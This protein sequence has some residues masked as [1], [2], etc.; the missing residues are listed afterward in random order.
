MKARRQDVRHIWYSNGGSGGAGGQTST[1]SSSAAAIKASS[2]N[3]D[4]DEVN[5]DE[6]FHGLYKNSHHSPD[7]NDRYP[8]LD[9]TA[10]VSDPSVGGDRSTLMSSTNSYHFSPSNSCLPHPPSSFYPPPPPPGSIE[11]LMSA[12][13]AAAGTAAGRLPLTPN[14]AASIAQHFQA[15]YAGLR[16][17][18]GQDLGPISLIGDGDGVEDEEEGEVE[19]VMSSCGVS[20]Y[21]ENQDSRDSL[22]SEPINHSSVID[23]ETTGRAGST[24]N[25][26]NSNKT[27]EMVVS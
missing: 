22:M 11:A 12:A 20:D 16:G 19:D 21:E 17:S 6:H 14:S 18:P 13:A 7:D 8:F 10:S 23:A 24:S 9:V 1:I 5:D 3:D 2:S 25:T 26:V 27:V 4:D 15:Y